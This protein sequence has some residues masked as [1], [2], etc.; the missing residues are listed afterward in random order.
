MTV[1]ALYWLHLPL[2]VKVHTV[3]SVEDSGF[4]VTLEEPLAYTHFGITESF[5]NGQFIDIRCV[6]LM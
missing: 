5:E 2:F 1:T 3:E 4:T 6:C